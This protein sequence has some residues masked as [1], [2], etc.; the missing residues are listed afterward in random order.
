MTIEAKYQCKE[1]GDIYDDKDG[2][3]N[4]C[5]PV[6]EVFECPICGRLFVDEAGAIACCD[7]SITTPKETA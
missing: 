4:C 2:A 7:K 6:R 5:Q 3:F 1:C